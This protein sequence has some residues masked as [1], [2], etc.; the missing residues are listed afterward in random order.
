[1][2]STALENQRIGNSIV[3]T[4]LRTLFRSHETRVEIDAES[5]E[6][7][8]DYIRNDN[9]I[10]DVVITSQHDAI[11]QLHHIQKLI[12]GIQDIHHVNAV[13]L[14]SLKFNYDPDGYTRGVIDRLAALNR[15][16]VVNPL[17]L[18][19]E[20]QFL[21][22]AEIEDA[23]QSLAKRLNLKGITVYANVPLLTDINDTPEE[24]N[25][26][27]FGL[28]AAGIEFHH[29]YVAGWPVQRQWNHE[30]PVD[31][32]DVIDIASRVRKDG[33]G[34]EI[35][36]YIILTELGEVDFGLTSRI[37][38]D[39]HAMRLTLLAYDFDYFKG[40]DPDFAWPEKVFTD[41]NGHPMVPMS[42]L[43]NTTDF[44]MV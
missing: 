43:I 44:F 30:H 23:H 15:L 42:G 3:S 8:I 32:A 17:R 19:I 2:Q 28:R 34:R 26:M 29:L 6:K 4:H 31:I 33:S 5:G 36:R 35:P 38:G 24:M 22:S 14:R 39:N 10:T 40:M 41:D 25:R 7:E 37:S 27:A 13:R 1:M 21:H 18:E 20:A 12:L 11:D 16:T 9:R